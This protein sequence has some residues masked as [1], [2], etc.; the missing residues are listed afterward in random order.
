MDGRRNRHLSLS[1][2]K[3]DYCN[4]SKF[5][6]MC[7]IAYWFNSKGLA[8]ISARSEHSVSHFDVASKCTSQILHIPSYTVMQW[9]ALSS[10]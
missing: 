9:S 4:P 3:K 6:L 8:I 7:H 5:S 2:I 10:M 1:A